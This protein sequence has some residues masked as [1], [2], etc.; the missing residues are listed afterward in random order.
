M[1]T[2]QECE[3]TYMRSLE[4]KRSRRGKEKVEGGSTE[5]TGSFNLINVLRQI[6]SFLSALQ[7]RR[8]GSRLANKNFS[9]AELS[10]TF[11]CV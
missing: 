4:K 9:F 5:T 10:K 7:R 8:R 11:F 6:N 2:T 1:V 3:K